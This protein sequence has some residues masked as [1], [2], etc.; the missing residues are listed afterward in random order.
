[1]RIVI[2]TNVIV[3][4][5]F[6]G[7]QP[8]QLLEHLLQQRFEAFV[9]REIVEEYQ[10]TVLYLQDKYPSKKV[11][12]PINHIVAAC[13]MIEQHTIISVCRD[14]D[15]D[16][17]IA[18]AVDARCVCLV[19]GDRDLLTLEKYQNIQIIS[20]TDFLQALEH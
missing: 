3:S 2:D 17:F 18:C 7:G 8:R 13:K 15:D 5:I 1:M 12:V 20:V 4:A 16:K 6:F 9:S 10:E 19:S 14:P 11:F